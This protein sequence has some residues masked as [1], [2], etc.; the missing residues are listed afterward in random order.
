[1]TK[2]RDDY[3]SS[4]SRRL[5]G[6]DCQ[7]IRNSCRVIPPRVGGWLVRVDPGVHLIYSFWWFFCVG[8]SVSVKVRRLLVDKCI[9]TRVYHFACVHPSDSFICSRVDTFR[10][11]ITS[12]PTSVIPVWSRDLWHSSSALPSAWPQ[13]SCRYF[14]LLCRLILCVWITLRLRCSTSYTTQK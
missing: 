2:M 5:Q 9:D 13:C 6:T 4:S 8:H 14:T 10:R 3:R 7:W 12:R 1:M 11:K